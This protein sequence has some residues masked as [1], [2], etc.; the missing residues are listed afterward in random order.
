M[1]WS[2]TVDGVSP[3]LRPVVVMLVNRKF[4]TRD[5]DRA[6][7]GIF[8]GAQGGKKDLVSPWQWTAIFCE[9]HFVSTWTKKKN[10][11]NDR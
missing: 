10:N 8:L 9:P 11:N 6:E 4:L 1:R 2:W 5:R 3:S 7:K